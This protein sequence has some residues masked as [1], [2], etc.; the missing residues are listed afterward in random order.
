M[1]VWRVAGPRVSETRAMAPLRRRICGMGDFA[2]A[3]VGDEKGAEKE[4]DVG[5]VADDENV[6]PFARL[7][8]EVLEVG[9]GGFGGERFGVEDLGLV[10]GLGGD[11]LGGLEGAFEGARDD[12]IEVDLEGVEDVGELQADA[13]C[14]PCRGDVLRR[15]GDWRGGC[16][17][18]RGGG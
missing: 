16:R 12:E 15:G 4:L 5:A 17:R 11:E 14:L 9:E 2:L 3:A 10:A 8:E 7:L 6:F 18:W 1:R 13:A